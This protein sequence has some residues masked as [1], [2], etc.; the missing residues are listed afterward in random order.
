MVVQKL[1]FLFH[2]VISLFRIRFDTNRGPKP[3]L[4]EGQNLPPVHRPVHIVLSLLIVKIA[5]ASGVAYILLSIVYGNHFLNLPCQCVDILI[6][7]TIPDCVNTIHAV[8]VVS[9]KN[10]RGLRLFC[11][12]RHIDTTPK[13]QRLQALKRRIPKE[14][15]K[16]EPG[17]SPGEVRASSPPLG[18]VLTPRTK[19]I[20]RGAYRME[21]APKA[22]A[23]SSP[24][25]DPP[26]S[27]A[28]C[29]IIV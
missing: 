18:T 15:N 23:P 17:R 24:P 10:N 16:T 11:F 3:Q 13:T 2:L 8:N 25:Y 29:S 9:V 4:Y 7:T 26:P 28:P 1:S 6:I 20:R 27:S 19:G 12:D 22:V 14:G 5:F 21:G